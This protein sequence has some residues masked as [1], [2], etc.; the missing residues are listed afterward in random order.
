MSQGRSNHARRQASVDFP[1]HPPQSS[2]PGLVA[3]YAQNVGQPSDY[4]SDNAAYLSDL[5][6][7]RPPQT[8]TNDELNLSVLQ[9]YNPEISSILSIAPYAVIYEFTPHPEPTWNKSGI[10]GSLFICQLSPGRRLGE[11]RYVVFV[12]NRRGLENFEAEL[13]EADNTCVE[14]TEEYVIVSLMEGGAQKIYGIFIFSEG[15]GSSTEKTRSLNAELMK[16]CATQAGISLKAAEAAAVEAVP[17]Q[18]NGHQYGAES[19]IDGL[20]MGVPM[21][22]QISLQE[23]FGRQREEDAG[24]SVRVHSPEG[25]EEGKIASQQAFGGSRQAQTGPPATS[26]QQQHSDVLGDLFRRAELGYQARS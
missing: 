13:R 26:P 7:A 5:P 10:E 2:V 12:L 18:N 17:S 20:A 22:R 9:R 19:A 3:Q 24:W 4:E 11:D 23:L 21:G 1:R 15:V 25:R 16:Q 6:A 14:I 8:R